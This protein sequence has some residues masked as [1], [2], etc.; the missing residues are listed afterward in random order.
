VLETFTVETFQAL[1]HD[2]FR[3]RPGDGSA[4]TLRL[5]EATSAGGG[6]A[7]AT[8]APFSILFQGP[9]QP[10]LVQRIYLLDHPALGEFEL[11]LVP[12]A[13]DGGGTT[14]QA[15]FG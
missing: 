14:Y 5:T 1:L 6:S 7:T 2:G 8:R 11:F 15:V 12:L 3:L 10:V 4:L 9:A 13:A